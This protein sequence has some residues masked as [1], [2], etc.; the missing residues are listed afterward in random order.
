MRIA[1]IIVRV[2]MGAL[3]VFASVTYFFNL[4]PQPQHTGALA[5]VMAGFAASKY[6]FP[7]TKAIELLAGLSFLSGKYMRL[8]N[9]VLLPVTVNILLIHVFLEP[10]SELAPAL[11]LLLGNL[12]LIYRNWDSYKWVFTA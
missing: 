8:F 3:L 1:T 12:F 10:L 7:L 4:F 6:L 9:I 11:L 5:T 2:L